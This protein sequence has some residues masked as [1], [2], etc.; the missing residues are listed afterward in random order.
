MYIVNI[1]LPLTS[2]QKDTSLAAKRANAEILLDFIIGD[3]NDEYDDQ[4]YYYRPLEDRMT[5]LATNEHR[6]PERKKCTTLLLGGPSSESGYQSK[7][8]PKTIC[9][10]VRCTACNFPVLQFPKGKWHDDVSPSFFQNNM[11]HKEQLLPKISKHKSTTAYACQCMW[12]NIDKRQKLP[13]SVPWT[14]SGHQ[15]YYYL[16]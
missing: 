8:Y 5:A 13:S 12:H 1:V 14:C 10:N 4:Q 7:S 6:E 3:F 9:C 2:S 11:P 16:Y 15:V